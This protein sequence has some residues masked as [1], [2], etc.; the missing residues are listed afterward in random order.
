M[1]P[2]TTTTRRCVMRS[3]GYIKELQEEEEVGEGGKGGY[4]GLT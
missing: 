2:K 4:M 3:S 1:R